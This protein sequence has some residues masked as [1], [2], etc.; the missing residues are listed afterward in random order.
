MNS[1]IYFYFF[2]ILFIISFK[3]KITES[4]NWKYKYILIY[5]GSFILFISLFVDNIVL[6]KYVFPFLIFLN[7]LILI[8]ITL[9]NKCSIIN[10]LAILC[11]I[12][13]LIKFNYKEI[14][15]K[16]GI[17]VNLNKKWLLTYIVGLSL[18][19]MFLN[20]NFIYFRTKFFNILLL[21]YPLV[22]PM[23]EYFIHRG[24]SLTITCLMSDTFNKFLKY[25]KLI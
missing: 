4:N 12:V 24:F 11:V 19:F 17:M 8:P 25:Y 6:N 18:Y 15:I 13:I 14:E 3:P 5:L 9:V 16:K 2:I 21:V 20:F 7:I 22:F 23:N 10:I 1:I